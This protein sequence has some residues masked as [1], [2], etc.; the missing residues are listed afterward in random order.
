MQLQIIRRRKPLLAH[1]T[2]VV[3]F[4]GVYPPVAPQTRLRI[5]PLPTYTTQKVTFILVALHV[6]CQNIFVFERLVALKAEN[7]IVEFVV[8]LGF[9]SG[10]FSLHGLSDSFVG[11]GQHGKALYRGWEKYVLM[12]TLELEFVH[13]DGFFD[14]VGADAVGVVFEE[15]KAGVSYWWWWF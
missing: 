10:G 2:F 4:A 6:C 9:Y 11:L 14:A 7:Y 3:F 12:R 5:E 15:L 8:L 13:D 1:L